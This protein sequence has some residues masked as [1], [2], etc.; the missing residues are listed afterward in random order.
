MRTVGEPTRD[1]SERAPALQPIP[2]V[3]GTHGAVASPH[4]LA[5]QAGLGILRGGGTAVD[6]AIATN[7]ALAVVA[8][9]ACGLGGDAFWLIHDPRT[10]QVLALNGSG[11]S[12]AAATLEAAAAAGL[13]EMPLRGPWTVTVPGA[14]HSWGAAHERFGSLSWAML[15]APAIELAEGFAASAR[16]IEAVE[17]TAQ[18]FGTHGDWARV[19]RPEGRSWRLGERVQLPA[20]AT[21]LR[22]IVNEGPDACYRGS[23]GARAGE[24]LAAAGSPLNER[25]FAEHESTWGAPIGVDY[26]GITSLSHP[27]N[28]C[29]VVALETL[30]ILSCFDPPPPSVFD[31][32][33]VADPRWVHLGLEASRL[34]LADREAWVT[35]PVSNP[36]VAERLLD[37]GWIE[38]RAGL[39][40]PDRAALPVA[41]TLPRGGGTIYLATAD[42]DGMVV[43]LIESNYAGFGSGLVD[44]ETGI[45]Y[46][47][48]GAFFRLDPSHPNVLAPRKRT[49]HT[50]TP[51]MLLR[52][53]KPWIAHGSMGGEIQPQ[54]F[55]QFVSGVVD[56]G[57]DIATAIGAPRWA[58]EVDGH[59]GTPSLTLLES[60]YHANVPTGL[61]ARHHDPILVDPWSSGM[62][63]AHA[64]EVVRDSPGA[65]PTF[66]AAADPRSEGLPGAW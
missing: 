36:G 15:L 11:R 17:G 21:T 27:P 48:R 1:S 64:V 49:V 28:S 10:T 33:G 22:R 29:G 30:A 40:D 19:Y 62:G 53:G 58:A 9:Y 60:R 14:V 16:W 5:T 56:G 51:G 24:W 12:A 26:R 57:L 50:L 25:D 47:N 46:Q 37:R 23:L 2:V 55:A 63:H 41:G 52:D 66:A 44:P 32:N 20:L 61:R 8:G 31:G 42:T 3:R 13:R 39:I 59:L 38:S 7:A 54:V 43:S 35:D 45:S 18:V 34:T 4:H 65:S 6:A